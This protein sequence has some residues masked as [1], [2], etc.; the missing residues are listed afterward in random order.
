MRNFDNRNSYHDNDGNLL[1]GRVRF[2]DLQ[3]KALNVYADSDGNTTLGN[4]VYTDSVGRIAEPQ[5]FLADYDYIAVFE[6]YVG[7]DSMNVDN[8]QDS[9]EY[10]FECLNMYKTFGKENPNG[11]TLQ[12]ITNMEELRSLDPAS[13][14]SVYLTDELGR[15][16]LSAEGKAI[17]AD[18]SDHEYAD[19]QRIVS[20]MGCVDVGDK[21]TVNYVWD[22]NCI[23]ED[24]G[25]SVISV[26]G[27]ERGRWILVPGFDYVDVRHF[28]V[29]PIQTMQSD[30]EQKAR[31]NLAKSYAESIGEQLYFPSTSTAMYY[32]VSGIS[33]N[34]VTAS[35][36]SRFFCV[37]GNNATFTNVS[38]IYISSDEG[39][40]GNVYVYGKTLYTSFNADQKENVHLVPSEKIVL[41][42]DLP[43]SL[44]LQDMNVEITFT[45]TYIRQFKNCVITGNGKLN[46][47]WAR[48]EKCHIY[49][50]MF[51]PTMITG[52][53][54]WLNLTF[55]NCNSDISDWTD[56]DRFVEY[57]SFTN[58]KVICTEGKE[59]FA[60]IVLSEDTEISNSVFKN[61]VELTSN[62]KKFR[63]TN[64]SRVEQLI[65]D[66][67]LENIDVIDSRLITQSN[68]CAA[69]S[70]LSNS[71]I[72]CSGSFQARLQ[73]PKID[74]CEFANITP[75]LCPDKVG[76]LT[77]TITNNIFENVT[78]TID[79][80]P[81]SGETQYLVKVDNLVVRGNFFNGT[82]REAIAY[83]KS[84]MNSVQG[85]YIVNDNI[86]ALS[87]SVIDRKR[88]GGQIQV[89]DKAY[90][91]TPVTRNDPY[92]DA[93]PLQDGNSWM[94][95]GAM[96]FKNFRIPL[97]DFGE[98]K[99]GNNHWYKVSNLVAHATQIWRSGDE[100]HTNEMNM[101]FTGNFYTDVGSAI[102]VSVPTR[103]VTYYGSQDVSGARDEPL[104]ATYSMTIELYDMNII[105]YAIM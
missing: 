50:D 105:N 67:E 42:T 65:V 7:E 5:V 49:Q 57:C 13:V 81:I 60:K 44:S 3:K 78:P 20:L 90:W 45:Q 100:E 69:K 99:N 18:E 38:E 22:K 71:Y 47:V 6:K 9:W 98:S 26:D 36:N 62:V 21:P 66:G 92:I 23:E 24:N 61:V 41:D 75:I 4:V 85:K 16:L 51:N 87:E 97:F 27:I 19:G 80:K 25:G 10:Q 8:E 33:V 37:S 53:E 63:V 40:D 34:N 82:A 86:G 56:I 46:C 88:V 73:Q 12:V 104:I 93:H 79:G 84:K 52:D 28:G 39:F 94:H 64:G 1:H 32:D 59:T 83:D 74:R 11:G 14:D 2:L 55:V 68:L 30:I 76:N 95:I 101:E 48:F 89:S 103:A 96:T 102:L 72:A 43:Y 54:A 17:V 58:R 91:P 70:N 29:F 77:A 35:K 31:I 15:I